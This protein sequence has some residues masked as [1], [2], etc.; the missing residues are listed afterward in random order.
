M[1]NTYFFRDKPL[2]GLDIGAGT[3]RAVQINGSAG[4][5][6][7]V[8]YGA[9]NFDINHTKNGVLTEPQAIATS[10]RHMFDI[11]SRGS[12]STS[13]VAL[14]LPAKRTYSRAISLP[15]LQP[16][17]MEAAIHLEAEQYIPFSINSLYLDYSIIRQTEKETELF[18]VAAPKTIVDSYIEL[19]RI[20][21]IEPV[22]IETS[23]DSATRLFSKTQYGDKPSVLVDFGQESVDITIVDKNILATGTVGGG[24]NDLTAKISQG[25]GV[26][27]Q[28]AQDIKHKYGLAAGNNQNAI[29][30][31]LN[32]QLELLYKEIRRMI[33][34]YNERSGGTK[35]INQIIIMGNG[36]S[37]P[38]L[39]ERMASVLN[40]PVILSDP[41]QMFKYGR[42]L[43]PIPD[44][45]KGSF[46]TAAGLAI[47]E[48][49]AVFK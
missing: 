30:M 35:Q 44:Q 13:R 18:M 32:P 46:I 11:N 9:A 8:A 6:K 37:L 1:R 39:S 28:E 16:E 36:A 25:L 43:S 49:K 45:H 2:F 15:K 34:Y 4:K 22:L 7:I 27:S 17:E 5:Q 31:A 21:N 23:I 40:I 26:S 48:P 10:F 20:L 41:W 42:G 14:S 19:A 38:G 12:F 3:L 47:A 29:I 33:R 24:S